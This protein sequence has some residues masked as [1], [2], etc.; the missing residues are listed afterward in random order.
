MAWEGK[1]YWDDWRNYLGG[2]VDERGLIE[3]IE[4][5]TVLLKGQHRSH[6]AKVLP[7]P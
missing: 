5:G 1:H 2:D 6:H 4:C 7:P 3:F